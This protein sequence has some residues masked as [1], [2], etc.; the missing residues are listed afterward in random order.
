MLNLILA[1]L[2]S[3]AILVA[4]KLF[5]R[6]G[7]R[8]IPAITVNYIVAVIFG[9]LQTDTELSLSSFLGKPWFALSL[10]VGLTFIITFYLYAASTQRVGVAL[11]SVAARMSVVIPVLLGLWLFRD[12]LPVLKLAGLL[13]ALVAVYLTFKKEGKM[14]LS[15]SAALFPLLLFLGNGTNDSLMKVVEHYY[16]RDD[17]EEFLTVVFFVALLT[18]ILVSLVKRERGQGA[19]NPRDLL[20]GLVLGLLNW[21]STYFFMSGMSF[22]DISVYVPLVS[23]SVVS[24]SALLGMFL[25]RERLSRINLIGIGLALVSIAIIASA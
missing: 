24:L 12:P 25:F 16:I 18:G 17:F 14:A 2:F 11:T 5:P 1:V 10:L 15:L 9:L 6:L 20:A 23:V 7:I 3:T 22:F 19:F 21:Y 4:F 13:L 8:V